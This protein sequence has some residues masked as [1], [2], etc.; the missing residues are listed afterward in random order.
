MD[1][2]EPSSYRERLFC[3]TFHGQWGVSMEDMEDEDT[4]PLPRYNPGSR[5]HL[6]ALVVISI[7]FANLQASID[8]LYRQ[9]GWIAGIQHEQPEADYFR[10]TEEDRV[11]ATNELVR[12]LDNDLVFVRAVENVL[13]YYN[14]CRDCRNIIIHSEQYPPAFGGKQDEL[15]MVK[16]T[17]A[18]PRKAQYARFTVARLRSIA[19]HIR[20]GVVQSAEINI[21]MRFRDTPRAVQFSEIPMILRIRL[22]SRAARHRV[23]RTLSPPLA[24]MML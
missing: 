2:T 21:Y 20:A 8:S 12:K 23:F 24:R 15:Y 14:W 11:K 18:P 6:H 1:F 19:D 10:L 16:W 3:V 22:R 9:R 17:K 5:N 4:W 13:D 7:T